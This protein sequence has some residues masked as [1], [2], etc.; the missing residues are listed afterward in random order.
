MVYGQNLIS[1]QQEEGRKEDFPK[2]SQ[3][4]YVENCQRGPITF[5]LCPFA[6]DDTAIDLNFQLMPVSDSKHFEHVYTVPYYA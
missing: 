3:M 6:K 5:V 4:G 1:R 2:L